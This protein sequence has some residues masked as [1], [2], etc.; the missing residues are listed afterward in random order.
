MADDGTGAG[1]APSAHDASLSIDDVEVVTFSAVVARLVAAY[2]SLSAARIEGVL[3]R[4]WEAFSAGRPIVVPVAVEA[5]V[6]EV[7]DAG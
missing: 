3:L 1:S 6:R 5:G 7:L 2:P 4:E